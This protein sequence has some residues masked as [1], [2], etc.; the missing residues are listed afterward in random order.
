MSQSVSLGSSA[1]TWRKA[2]S[3]GYFGG[4]R[5]RVI[6]HWKHQG[7][8]TCL[9]ALMELYDTRGAFSVKWDVKL[10]CLLGRLCAV[11]VP[12]AS[13]AIFQLLPLFVATAVVLLN[14]YI[15]FSRVAVVLYFFF[16]SGFFHLPAVWGDHMAQL[17][18]QDLQAIPTQAVHQ[19]RAARQRRKWR[20]EVGKITSKNKISE[21]S[22]LVSGDRQLPPRQPPWALLSSATACSLCMVWDAGVVTYPLFLTKVS[23]TGGSQ[24]AGSSGPQ[25]WPEN[26]WAASSGCSL[27]GVWHGMGWHGMESIYVFLDNSAPLQVS[28]SFS[29]VQGTDYWYMPKGIMWLNKW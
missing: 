11:A 4:K 29:H 13:W 24:L 1:N 28:T 15:K 26:N 22:G 7:C 8:H 25:P 19:S 2:A 23:L 27:E 17:L 21:Y 14:C 12:C 9:C 3:G 10:S 5:S 20:R 16:P 6:Y 18:H